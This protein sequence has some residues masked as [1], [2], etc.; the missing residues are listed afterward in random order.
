MAPVSVFTTAISSFV[1]SG[2]PNDEMI[3][4]NAETAGMNDESKQ[5]NDETATANEKPR[6][7]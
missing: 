2:C 7:P 3:C 4:R 5:A 6:P 1:P